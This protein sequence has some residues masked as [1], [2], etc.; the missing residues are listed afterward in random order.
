VQQALGRQFVY[1]VG[2]GD[3][4][5]ARDVQPG[6]WSGTRWII[7]KGLSPGERVVVDGLQKLRP[8][9]VVRPVL[10]ED[11]VSQ[12][13]LGVTPAAEGESR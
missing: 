3:S 2:N 1:V 6:E 11:S 10:V 9:A 12:A 7:A 5:V 4:V 13:A 8:G